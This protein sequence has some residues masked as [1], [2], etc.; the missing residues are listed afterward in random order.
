MQEW[1]TTRQVRRQDRI[2]PKAE[3]QKDELSQ[4]GRG[5]PKSERT[6]FG[7]NERR[8]EGRVE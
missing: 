8:V 3:G 5:Q 2:T 6:V 4:S 7:R 1:S